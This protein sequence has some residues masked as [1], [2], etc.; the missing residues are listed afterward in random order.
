MTRIEHVFSTVKTTKNLSFEKI[1][2]EDEK[3]DIEKLSKTDAVI[4]ELCTTLKA[5]NLD[6]ESILDKLDRRKKKNIISHLNGNGYRLL[7]FDKKIHDDLLALVYKEFGVKEI[8]VKND[9]FETD[10]KGFIDL[11]NCDLD[12]PFD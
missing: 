9:E 12:V 6:F 8:T 11:E 7:E 2:I 10:E 5:N 1:Y 3:E 4:V